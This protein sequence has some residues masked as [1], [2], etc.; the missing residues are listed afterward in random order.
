MKKNKLNALNRKH[1]VHGRDFHKM[2]IPEY[3]AEILSYY[4]NQLT[5]T[6]HYVTHERAKKIIDD[7]DC[8][9]TIDE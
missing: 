5:G 3:E 2:P 8:K 4:I 7:Y 1:G 6:G 9:P